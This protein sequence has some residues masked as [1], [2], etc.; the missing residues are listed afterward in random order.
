MP[1][2]LPQVEHRGK[3]VVAIVVAE[4]PRAVSCQACR[5][6]GAELT[7]D[8][9]QIAGALVSVDDRMHFSIQPAVNRVDDAVATAKLWL[10]DKGRREDSLAGVCERDV[11]RVIHPARHDDVDGRIAGSAPEDVRGAGDERRLPWTFVG[12][13]GECPLVQ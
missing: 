7:E 4:R 3:E 9:H 8:R 5:N 13:L 6:R 10:F 2:D 12:L 11:D 1:R